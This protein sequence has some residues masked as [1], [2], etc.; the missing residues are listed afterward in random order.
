MGIKQVS[1]VLLRNI[2]NL[3]GWRTH[4]KIVIIESDD[5]GSIRMPSKTT[6]NSLL[7]KGIKLTSNGTSIFNQY[8]SL[9]SNNDLTALF[10]TLS[11][12]KDKNGNHPV[13]TPLCVVANPDFEKI[14]NSGFEEYYYENFN[15]TLLKYK[16]RE[17]VYDLWLEGIRNKLFVPQFHGREHLNVAVWM[18]ALKENDPDTHFAFNNG[19]WGFKNRHPHNISNQAAFE[20]SDPTEITSQTAILADGL[21]VFKKLLGY[22]AS[23]FV[24]PNGAINNRLEL[25]ASSAGI[26]YMYGERFQHESLGNGKTK[27]HWHYLGQKNKHSQIYLSR[28]CNFETSVDNRDWVN[29]CLSSINTVFK[30][31]KPAI[32][33]THRVNYIGAI[34]PANR[35]KGIR[36]LNELLATVVK[37]WPDVEFMTSTDLGALIA[38]TRV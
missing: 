15:E 37:I 38:K 21:S 19:M 27:I 25:A 29:E 3:P 10:E 14:S 4:R 1:R 23:Y 31:K 5:W 6:Y 30:W 36:N 2:A 12:F 20:L 16:G 22:K 18:K 8:D 11:K 24:P 7:E 17:N 28:N 33:N 34:D 26:K 9:E 32:I 35:D 13:F